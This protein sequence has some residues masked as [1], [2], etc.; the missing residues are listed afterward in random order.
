MEPW[1]F[2]YLFAPLHSEP[3][4]VDS[5]QLEIRSI[6]PSPLFNV[7]FTLMM[8]AVKNIAKIDID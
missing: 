6:N 5:I 3:W 1:L 8:K 4:I 2:D 7:I